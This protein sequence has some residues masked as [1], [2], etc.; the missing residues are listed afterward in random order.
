MQKGIVS[1][2]GTNTLLLRDLKRLDKH[3][4]SEDKNE[5]RLFGIVRN[6]NLRLPY[7]LDYHRSIGVARFFIVDNDSGDGT[8]V[9]SILRVLTRPRAPA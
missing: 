1:K 6:E 5:I 7:F 8:A 9:F 4:I 3:R 2:A